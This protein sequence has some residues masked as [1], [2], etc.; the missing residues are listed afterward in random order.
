MTIIY[1]L[2]AFFLLISF[3]KD[4]EKTVKAL[5]V[6][7]KKLLKILPAFIVMLIAVSIVLYFIP[8]HAIVEH[9]NGTSKWI[10]FI[11]AMVLGS[12]A[13]MP[14]FVA[15]PLGG[16]LLGKGVSHMVI[17]AFTT[18]LMMVGLVTFPIE[19]VYLGTKVAILRNVIS[20]FIAIATAIVTAFF[21]GELF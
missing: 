9:L 4:R 3:L 17:S 13:V 1:S 8:E 18:T 12:I 5:K 15:F 6:A 10:S 11:S 20:L 2:T 16:I 21:Y 14:G 19:K 7:W